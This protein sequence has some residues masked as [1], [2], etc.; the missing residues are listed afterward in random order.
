MKPLFGPAKASV[1]EARVVARAPVPGPSREPPWYGWWSVLWAA[2]SALALAGLAAC[3]GPDGTA[4][5]SRAV[6]ANA[7]LSGVVTR[8]GE[9]AEGVEIVVTA[10]PNDEILAALGDGEPVPTRELARVST[11]REGWFVVTLDPQEVGADHTREDGMVDLD[12]W[13]G[14]GIGPTA[15]PHSYSFTAMPNTSGRGGGTWASD[16]FDDAEFAAR[17]AEGKAPMHV[18][19]EIGDDP[20]LIEEG[21]ELVFWR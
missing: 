6:D 10:W 4:P 2:V 18:L 8:N 16:H 11:D 17:A 19:V 1:A 20:S 9:P 21:S 3:G 5:I 12:I 13:F 15:R 14:I 7:V